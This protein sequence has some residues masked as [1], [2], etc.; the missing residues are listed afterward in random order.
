MTYTPLSSSRQRGKRIRI[1]VGEAQEQHGQPLY[2]LLLEAAYQHGATAATVLRGIEG[3]GPEL[4]LSTDRFPDIADNLPLVVD[5]VIQEECVQSLL[6]AL[7]PLV[8]QGMVTSTP[9]E[10]LLPGGNA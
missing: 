6:T 1:F 8:Q 3:F 10:I 4:H 2:R 9:I 7:D 5:I